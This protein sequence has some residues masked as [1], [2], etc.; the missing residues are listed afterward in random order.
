MKRIPALILAA[1]VLA[2]ALAGCSD[3]DMS[4]PAPTETAAAGPTQAPAPQVFT[5]PCTSTA[6][7]HPLSAGSSMDLALCG[8]MFEGLYALDTHFSPQPCLCSG[9]SVSEDGLIWTFSLR[10]GITFSDGSPLTAEDAAY[11][12]RAAR[13]SALYSSRLSG[14]SAVSAGDGAVQVT[15]SAPNGL[16]PALLDVPIFK[17]AEDAA[18]GTGPYV[19][20]AG[21][22]LTARAGWWRGAALPVQT[23]ALYPVDNSE[24][25]VRAFDTG[26]ITLLSVDYSDADRPGFSGNFESCDLNASTM[27][28]LGFQC[29]KGPCADGSFRSALSRC[30]DRET[31]CSLLFARHAQAAAVPVHPAAAFYP[32]G[33]ARM[34]SYSPDSAGQLLSELGYSQN[35]DGLLE[36]NGQPLTLTLV[37][38]EGNALHTQLAAWYQNVL[39]ELGVALSVRALTWTEYTAALAAGDFDLY[40]AQTRLTADFDPASL[41]SGALNYGGYSS[42]ALADLLAAYRAAGED[43]RAAAAEALYAQF[44]QAPSIAP[45]CFK[46]LSILTQWGQVAGMTPTQQNLFYGFSDWTLFPDSGTLP[47]E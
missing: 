35:G 45:V 20:S 36:R 38:N 13:E 34:L 32:D 5:L 3:A 27:F 19:W 37:V 16:L 14:I 11:S 41:L 8:L 46:N 15:L 30:L 39:K 29:R 6:A 33:A 40:L 24:E 28:Y 43:S 22:T 23:I 17:E 26:S 2:G 12:L 10:P 21:P 31:I 18:V 42:Q 25:L 7:P 4:T 1:A 47:G 44:V 9:S